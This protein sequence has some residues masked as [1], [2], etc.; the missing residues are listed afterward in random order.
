MG[1]LT[2]PEDREK[3]WLHDP[4]THYVRAQYLRSKKH[5]HTREVILDLACD[6]RTRIGAVTRGLKLSTHGRDF[7]LKDQGCL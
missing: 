3:I 2:S 6:A 1:L 5:L 4:M 7:T